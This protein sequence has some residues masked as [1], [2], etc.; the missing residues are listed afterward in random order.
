MFTHTFSG[1]D[2]QWYN[3]TSSSGRT[4]AEEERELLQQRDEDMLNEALYVCELASSHG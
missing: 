1:K 3:K 2:L 4:A